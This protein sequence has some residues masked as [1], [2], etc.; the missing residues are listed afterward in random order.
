MKLEGRQTTPLNTLTK[1]GAW[2]LDNRTRSPTEPCRN[3]RYQQNLQEIKHSLF[4]IPLPKDYQ[5]LPSQ[6]FYYPHRHKTLEDYSEELEL[7]VRPGNCPRTPDLDNLDA[8]LRCPENTRYSN[9]FYP[10]RNTAT[11]MKFHKRPPNPTVEKRKLRERIDCI[12]LGVTE[13]KLYE[14]ERPEKL[15]GYS[16]KLRISKDFPGKRHRSTSIA[17]NNTSVVR[18]TRQH[19]DRYLSPWLNPHEEMVDF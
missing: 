6:S 11:C 18:L 14:K 7:V 1:N 5:V 10:R 8:M 15:D 3:N 17:P 9:E 12:Q 16:R 4:E 19:T 13:M 2:S